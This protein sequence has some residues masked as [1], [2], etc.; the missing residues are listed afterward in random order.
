M[1]PDTMGKKSKASRAKAKAGAGDGSSGPKGGGGS[2]G[3]AAGGAMVT[4]NKKQNCVRCFGTVKADKGTAC[5]GCSLLYCWRCEKKSFT[6]CPNGTECVH[7]IR[8]CQLCVVGATIFRVL[9]EKEELRL[10][11]KEVEEEKEEARMKMVMADKVNR[12][13]PVAKVA[14]R[15]R[16]RRIEDRDRQVTGSDLYEIEVEIVSYF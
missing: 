7:P 14:E 16:L 2:G 10:R 13:L 9:E 11:L 12:S 3:G 6:A 4:S 1:R 5:P 15:K 8:R